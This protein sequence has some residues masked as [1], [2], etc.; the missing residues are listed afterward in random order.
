MDRSKRAN[1][2]ECFDDKGR[3]KKGARML[4]VRAPGMFVRMFERKAATGGELIA[5]GNAQHVPV[6]VPPR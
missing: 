2:P 3:W 1:N 5:F 4:K 6:P